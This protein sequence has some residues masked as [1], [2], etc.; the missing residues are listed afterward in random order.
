MSDGLG[1]V[2]NIVLW[3]NAEASS[4]IIL[5]CI[6]TMKPIYVSIRQRYWPQTSSTNSNNRKPHS[7]NTSKYWRSFAAPASVT[8][9]AEGA[10]QYRQVDEYSMDSRPGVGGK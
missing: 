9:K 2:V 6:P 3:S 4:A 5:S 8:D 1:A 7:S 10:A